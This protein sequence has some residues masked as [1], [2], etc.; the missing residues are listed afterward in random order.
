MVGSLL[1]LEDPVLFVLCGLPGSFRKS[2]FSDVVRAQLG[3]A[4][5][6]ALR[7]VE[8][9]DILRERSAQSVATKIEDP[10]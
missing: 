1:G 7:E 4:V 9:E 10:P 8:R 2:A 6:V 5:S 3:N